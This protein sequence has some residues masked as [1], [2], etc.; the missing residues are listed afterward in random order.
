MARPGTITRATWMAALLC[1]LGALP[2]LGQIPVEEYA[3]RR[4][5]LA[6]RIGTG[7]VV[8]FG[9]RTPVTDF[10]PPTQ[11]PAFHYLTNEITRDEGALNVRRS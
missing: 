3:V 9:A 5:S 6:A 11:L 1:S 8:A 7:V 10:G 2:L 4:D